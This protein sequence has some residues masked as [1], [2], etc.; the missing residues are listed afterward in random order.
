MKISKCAGTVGLLL[1]ASFGCGSSGSSDPGTTNPGGGNPAGGSGTSASGT[2]GTGTSGTANPSGGSGQSGGANPS[3]GSANPSGGSGQSGGDGSGGAVSPVSCTLSATS[4]LSTKIPTVGIVEWSTDLAGVDAA[5]IEFGLDTKYGMSAPVDLTAPKYRTLLLGMKASH[6]YHFRVV[7]GSGAKQC[8][9]EDFTVKT[10]MLANDLP[11]VDIKTSSPQAL[12]GGFMVTGTFQDGPAYILDAD[13]DI[14]WW[15]GTGEVTRARMSYDGK[16]MW[17][18][19]GNV[20]E[21][22]AKVVRV[23][24]DGLD[25]KDLTSEFAGLNHD[26]VVLPDESVIYIAY[27]NGCDKIMERSPDGKNRE[28][29]KVRKALELG[30]SAPCHSNALGYSQWDDSVVVS[31]LDN[32]SYFKVTRAGKLVW[33]LGG[34]GS[35]FTGAS[36]DNNHGLDL[37]AEDR[38][39]I[40]NN[41]PMGQGSGSRAIELKLDLTAKTATR[42]WEYFAQ[43]TIANAIMGDVQRLWNGNTLVTYSTQGVVHEVNAAKEVLQEIE[44]PLGGAI[45]YVS[46]RQSLYGPPPSHFSK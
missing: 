9:S 5:H 18:A 42:A 29:I 33:V 7:A 36:W 37:L 28:I 25:A 35:D 15:Y 45:G 30:D 11:D 23:S 22:Q 6:T 3:G 46:K 27:D 26:L 2:S 38:L 44:W 31:E 39:L 24:M 13:G 40:F 12:A 43:P 20:P 1:G 17:I 4:S 41:G 8:T 19:K 16:Y 34:T 10:G 14:V 32:D 21:G